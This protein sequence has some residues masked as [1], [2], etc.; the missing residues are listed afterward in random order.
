VAQEDGQVASAFIEQGVHP[1]ASETETIRK[2]PRSARAIFGRLERGNIYK[3]ISCSPGSGNNIFP[4]P[5]SA[6]T[7][8]DKPKIAV[9]V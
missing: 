7:N 6:R 2:S 5:A 3:I 8:L 1:A 9:M 4:R